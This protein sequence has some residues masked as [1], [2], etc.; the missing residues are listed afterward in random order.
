M[1]ETT[2]TDPRTLSLS[3]I[4]RELTEVAAKVREALE[5]G[6]RIGE[7]SARLFRLRAEQ[8][9]REKTNGRS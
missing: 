1:I 5:R 4:E 8:R 9:F 6:D 7:L 2:W 3:E